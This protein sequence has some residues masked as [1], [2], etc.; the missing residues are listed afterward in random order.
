MR[1][2]RSLEYCPG[3]REELLPGFTPDFP[4]IASQAELDYYAGGIVP[5]HW[6]KEVELFYMESGTLEYVTPKGT[7]TFLAGSG[8]FVNSNILHMT[9]SIAEAEENIQILHIFDTSFLSGEQGSRIE[10]KYVTPIIAAPQI[11]VVAFSQNDPKQAEILRLIQNA[12]LLS[13]EEFG[14]E[15][16]LRESLSHIWLLLFDM[17]RPRLDHGMR[18]DKDKNSE[19]L[20]L[21]MIFVRENFAEKITISD[22]ASAAYLSERECFRIFQKSLHVTP[23]EYIKSVRLQEACKLLAKTQRPITS[24]FHACGFGSSSYFGKTFREAMGCTPLEYRQKWQNTD[25][26]SSAKI[27]VRT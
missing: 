1:E 4:Y 25:G 15:F 14:Y 5:W 23:V 21:M 27:E 10:Q 8:G 12:F 7:Q 19:Y 18:Y 9:R 6:H 22:L 3:S 20:K 17:L 16:K 11:E 26:I 2:R 24:I 13:E